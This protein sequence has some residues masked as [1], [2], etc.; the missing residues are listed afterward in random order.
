MTLWTK[1]CDGGN[2]LGCANL[3]YMYDQ[4]LGVD[5]DLAKARALYTQACDMNE[6][7]ACNR[8]A[9]MDK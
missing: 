2:A 9:E 8:L 1:S 5:R 3:G 4:A 7:W 6:S